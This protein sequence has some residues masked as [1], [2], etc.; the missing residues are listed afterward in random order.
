[1]RGASGEWIE[2]TDP[3]RTPINLETIAHALANTCRWGGH[4]SRFYSVAAHSIHVMALLENTYGLEGAR[5]GLMHDAHEAYTGDCPSPIK[6]VLGQAWRHFERG[7]EQRVHAHFGLPVA[8]DPI[9][10]PCKHAD[11][12]SLA[13]E[14]DRLLAPGDW[15]RW[16]KLPDPDLDWVLD[17]RE[18]RI[19]AQ[20]FLRHADRLG[21][22]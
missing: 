12:V 10:S 14:R 19:I 11:N 4:C 15:K 2:C 5:A 20:D 8:A 9:W 16:R 7:W 13:T 6:I 3:W 22:K 17:H 18:P 1:M 21:L